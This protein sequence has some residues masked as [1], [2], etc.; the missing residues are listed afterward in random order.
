MPVFSWVLWNNRILMLTER[1][2]SSSSP[3]YQ[4]N[5]VLGVFM[6]DLTEDTRW[7][8]SF[9]YVLC[10]GAIVPAASPDLQ[11]KLRA[12]PWLSSLSLRWS[13]PY[14]FLLSTADAFA[15]AI[16]RVFWNSLSFEPLS[17][18]QEVPCAIH[19]HGTHPVFRENPAAEATF[20]CGPFQHQFWPGFVE[21]GGCGWRVF[22]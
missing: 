14:Y 2:T 1:K 22:R 19:P 13:F 16:P 5:P 6:Q 3:Q 8:E 15:Y 11:V 20:G 4:F 17:H 7:L 9:R 12:R 10:A 18:P 21:S